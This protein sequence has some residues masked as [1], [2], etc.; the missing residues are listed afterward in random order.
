MKLGLKHQ[1]QILNNNKINTTPNGSQIQHQPLTISI[2]SNVCWYFH[3]EVQDVKITLL[4][5]TGSSTSLISK[6][7]YEQMVETPRLKQVEAE[8]IAANGTKLD[9][10]IQAEF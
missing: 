4:F 2:V 1:L 3:A 5:D 10:W 8:F 9:T 7:T 6:E